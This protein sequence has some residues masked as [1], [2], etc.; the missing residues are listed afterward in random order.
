LE[1]SFRAQ[2]VGRSIRRRTLRAIPSLTAHF[3]VDST[4][5]A[6]V[7]ATGSEKV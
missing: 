4:T 3:A 6:F 2:M 1:F 7:F 5:S